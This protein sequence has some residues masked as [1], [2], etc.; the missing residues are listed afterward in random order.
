MANKGATTNS[1]AYLID[2]ILL[3]VL[4][5]MLTYITQSVAANAHKLHQFHH[6]DW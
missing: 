4:L 1:I 5:I 6:P 2:N 3:E